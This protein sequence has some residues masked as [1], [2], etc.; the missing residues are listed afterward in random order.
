MNREEG[1]EPPSSATE[2]LPFPASELPWSADF[3]MQAIEVLP[4]TLADDIILSLGPDHA[5][6]FIVGRPAGAKPEQVAGAP[7]Q[8]LGLRPVVL[9]SPSWRHDR[10]EVVLT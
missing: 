3:V 10:P 1:P 5:A 9:H 6:S 8:G 7:V 4:V 2:G